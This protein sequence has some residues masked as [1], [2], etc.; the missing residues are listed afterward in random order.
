[1]TR[2]SKKW[3][4][5]KPTLYDHFP[6]DSSNFK[7][8]KKTNPSQAKLNVKSKRDNN[9]DSRFEALKKEIQGTVEAALTEARIKSE[10]IE[11]LKEKIT[12]LTEGTVHF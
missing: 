3:P 2:F 7:K 8:Y 6:H 5:W 11:A 4:L 12:K 10:E 1:M 9:E